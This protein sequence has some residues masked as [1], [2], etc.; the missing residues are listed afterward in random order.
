MTVMITLWMHDVDIV[1]MLLVKHHVQ[2]VWML[3][4]SSAV[5]LLEITMGQP[6]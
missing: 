6:K 2:Q 4:P 5:F 3:N 1:L